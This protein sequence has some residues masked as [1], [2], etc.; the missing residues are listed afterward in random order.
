VTA[1]DTLTIPVPLLQPLGLPLDGSAVQEVWDTFVKPDQD[2]GIP[3]SVEM[4]ALMAIL[5]A[6]HAGYAHEEAVE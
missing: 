1:P 4:R 6:V 2:A 3:Q 5:R